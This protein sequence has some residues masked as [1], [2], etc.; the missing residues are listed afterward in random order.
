[1]PIVTTRPI[2]GAH[3]ADG[4]FRQY[5]VR[6]DALAGEYAKT[7]LFFSVLE[8]CGD[9][10]NVCIGAIVR[11]EQRFHFAPHFTIGA[12]AIQKRRSFN[13]IEFEGGF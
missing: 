8:R 5:L 9:I 2:H 3:A 12:C 13:P 10:E 6:A 7:R 4:N 11:S 1:L